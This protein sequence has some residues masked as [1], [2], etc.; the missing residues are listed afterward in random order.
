MFHLLSLQVLL[1]KARTLY[2]LQVASYL[3]SD[4]RRPLSIYISRGKAVRG[5]EAG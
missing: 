3:P 2:L 1:S 4:R 5:V